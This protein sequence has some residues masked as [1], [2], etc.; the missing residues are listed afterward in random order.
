ME[1]SGGGVVLAIWRFAAVWPFCWRAQ[2]VTKEALVTA[3]VSAE[4][5]RATSECPIGAS[6]HLPFTGFLVCLEAGGHDS[7]G[8][9]AGSNLQYLVSR[10]E[11]AWG[12][13]GLHLAWLGCA[14]SDWPIGSAAC[15][16]PVP[17]VGAAAFGSDVGGNVRV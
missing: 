5:V 17:W 6:I 15:L 9:G 2:G 10:T 7:M 4:T 13:R 16:N 14:D 11:K 12:N 1:P 3:E 8:R